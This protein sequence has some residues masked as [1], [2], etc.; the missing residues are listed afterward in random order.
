MPLADAQHAVHTAIDLLDT[1]E[2]RVAEIVD[3]E[4]VVHEWLKYAV[5]L[6]FRLAHM[7]TTELGPFEYHDKIP[8]KRHYA[9]VE[10]ARRARGVGAVGLVPR[11]GRDPDAELHEHR[12]PGRRRHHGR[13]VG[14]GR[15][16]RADRRAR[17]PL[18]WRRHRWRARA[19]AGRAGHHRRRLHDRQPLHGHAGRAR[20]RRLRA[21][22][23]RDPQPRHPRDRRGDRRRS[24][25]WR[26][27]AVVDR[28]AGGPQADVP[29]WRV[30]A[31]VR[32]DHAPARAEG[33][34]HDKAKLND[35]LRDHGIA[36]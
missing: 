2:A 34:R 7:D 23:G 8:L 4:V 26:R 28:G 22:R 5:L 9:A 13:H 27:A 19:A 29:R 10:G 33:E 12:R 17:A 20:R 36:T 1:G 24:V 6:L 21:R 14:D 32:A 30:H 16:V 35:I 18:G 15:L 31:A 25:A 11:A 3:D